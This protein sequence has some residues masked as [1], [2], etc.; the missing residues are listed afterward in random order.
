M[1]P[2]PTASW[3]EVLNDIVEMNEKGCF[4][5]GAAGGTFDNITRLGGGTSLTAAVPGSAAASI[6]E[7]TGLDLNVQAFPPADGQ[8]AFTVTWRQLRLGHQRLVR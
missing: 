1:S 3:K 2:S 6:G 7:A 4:Q 8:N 5:D